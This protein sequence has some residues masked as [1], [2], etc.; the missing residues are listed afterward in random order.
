MKR[1]T[2]IMTSLNSMKIPKKTFGIHSHWKPYLVKLAIAG[3]R[4]AACSRSRFR[5]VRAPRPFH[6]SFVYLI[7]FSCIQ[8]KTKQWTLIR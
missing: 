3:L 5:F 2:L 6:E 8:T 4:P 7:G 1:C